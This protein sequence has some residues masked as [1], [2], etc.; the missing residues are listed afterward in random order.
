VHEVGAAGLDDL[1]ELLGLALQGR[2]EGVERGEQVVDDGGR[3]GDVDRGREHV[4]GG[5]RGVDVVV[6][7]DAAP[8]QRARDV[9]D[10]LVGVHVRRRARAGLEDVDREVL[11]VL[12]GDD[13]LGGL[14]DGPREVLLEDPELGVGERGG[15]LDLREG[16]DVVPRQARAGDGEV[17]HRALRLGAVEGA[18]RDPHLP[19]GVVLDAE[20]FVLRHCCSKAWLAGT[21]C[22]GCYFSSRSL[23]SSSARESRTS[24][25]RSPSAVRT[26]FS[27]YFA[28]R[29][30]TPR[31]LAASTGAPPSLAIFTGM[32]EDRKSTRLNS[33]HVKI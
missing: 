28:P 10:D 13:L 24:S 20:G 6:G 22:G 3:G 15:A 25:A 18:A 8:E 2:R 27:W 16:S 5:L 1:G 26:T 33:S 4:V 9:R 30:M 21:G 7:V 12:A 19:H 32:P 17:L 31:M 23:L 14:G 29:V 11:V